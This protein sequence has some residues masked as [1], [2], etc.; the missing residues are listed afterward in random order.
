MLA[1]S[2]KH[3]SASSFA[4]VAPDARTASAAAAMAMASG[5]PLGSAPSRFDCRRSQC[6]CNSREGV[7]TEHTTGATAASAL[8]AKL[9]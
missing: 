1:D 7:V 9:W 5:E 6:S 4:S 8:S 3:Q 2:T